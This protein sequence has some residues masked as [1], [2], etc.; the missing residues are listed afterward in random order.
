MVADFMR[1]KA[2]QM[3]TVENPLAVES[4]RIRYGSYKTLESIT[5]FP[6]LR[7]L[8]IAAFPNASLEPLGTLPNLRHLRILHLPKIEAPYGGRQRLS[9][10]TQPGARSGVEHDAARGG[11]RLPPGDRGDP[12]GVS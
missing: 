7:T 10:P 8:V 4:L 3:P 12:E 11:Q 9:Q 1:D 5:V 2:G 6:N